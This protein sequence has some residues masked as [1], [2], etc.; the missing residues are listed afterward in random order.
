MEGWTDWLAGNGNK[1]KLVPLEGKHALQQI[2]NSIDK[3][4]CQLDWCLGL[5]VVAAV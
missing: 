1:A 4:V 3:Q 5:P 2:S